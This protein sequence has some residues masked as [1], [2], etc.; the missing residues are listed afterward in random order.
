MNVVIINNINEIVDTTDNKPGDPL[1]T[2]DGAK[3][4]SYTVESRSLLSAVSNAYI[5]VL[6]AMPAISEEDKIYIMHG[7][8]SS[9]LVTNKYTFIVGVS[10]VSDLDTR[11]AEVTKEAPIPVVTEDSTNK[12]AESDA[13]IVE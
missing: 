1:I 9:N 11:L 6:K 12:S 10:G 8:L 4:V 3:L 5:S 13:E 2:D 7:N